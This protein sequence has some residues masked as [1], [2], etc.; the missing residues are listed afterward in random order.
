MRPA[1]DLDRP[2]PSE[3]ARDRLVAAGIFAAV[4]GVGLLLSRSVWDSYDARIM[5]S[6]ATSIVN[7]GSITVPYDSYHLN[8]PHS[9]YGIGLSLLMIPPMQ[10]FKLAGS[11]Q[12]AGQMLT[13]AVLLG[14]LAVV[15]YTWARIRS[16][17]A[18]ASAAVALSVALGGGLLAYSATGMSEIG[19]AVSVAVGLLAVTQIRLGHRAGPW[20]LGTAVGA[21]VIMRDDSALRVAPWLLAG[22]W[23]A[24]PRTSRWG[25]LGR[26]AVAGIP[27]AGLWA[28]YNYARYGSP[29]KV[30]YSGVL[31]FNH[32]FLAG[33]YGLVLSPGRG[34]ILYAPLVLVAGAGMVRAWR[35]DPVLCTVAAGLLL[36]RVVFY[37]PYWGWYGG[38]GWGP[39]YLLAAVPALAVGLMEILAG[40]GALRVGAR[41]LVAVLAALSVSIGFIG[42]AVDY[43]R[44][45]LQRELA[46]IPG[47]TLP[48]RTGREFVQLLE[49]RRIQSGVDHAMFDWGVFPIPDEASMLIH[50]R[51]LVSDALRR[52]ADKL[53]DV[54]GLLLV[55][56]GSV[57]MVIGVRWRKTESKQVVRAASEP[58]LAGQ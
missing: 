52:P 39:R 22:A 53:R 33:L 38:G 21:S 3:R 58:E 23:F 31:T 5:G 40:F 24:A 8:S 54:L 51:D 10:L 37:S 20:L 11:T 55:A 32:S 48:T 27:W 44:S 9:F 42:G 4:T 28:W 14:V 36:G 45:A 7:H 56:T 13:N 19:L 57:A 34:Y 43:E 47:A 12:M 35:R 46:R 49:S 2:A 26:V 15:L 30:G 50:R 29:T 6:V 16:F 17:S 41:V 25:T 18:G 1:E